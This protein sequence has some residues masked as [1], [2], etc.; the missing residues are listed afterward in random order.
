MKY[1]IEPSLAE[2]LAAILEDARSFGLEWATFRVQDDQI[3]PENWTMHHYEIAARENLLMAPNTEVIRINEFL[4]ELYRFI[5][6]TPEQMQQAV[7][8]YELKTQLADLGFSEP[9]VTDQLRGFIAGG[10]TG[11]P[12]I[13]ITKPAGDEE[14]HFKLGFIQGFSGMELTTIA[15]AL[16]IRAK[17][18][19]QHLQYFQPDVPSAMAIELLQL[20]R[21]QPQM[22]RDNLIPLNFTQTQEHIHLLKTQEKTMNTENLN[23]LQK[24]LL[25]LGFGEKLNGALE[26]NI[27]AARKEFTLATD[28]EY[29][30]QNV[31]YTL[32][33]KAGDNN[34]M[35]FFNKYDAALRDKEMQQTFYINKGSG[36]TAKEAYNLMEGRAVHKQLENLEGEKYHAWIVIDKEN[37]T[38][39]GNFKLRPFTEGWN[40]K[41]E[42]AIDKLD[43]VGINEEGAREKLMKSLEKGN[44]HQVTAMKDGK[45]VKLYLE[46]NPAEH[47]VNLTNWK[48]EAQQLEHYKR[49]ELKNEV[50][51]DQKQA[52][53]TEDAPAKKQRKGAKMK[54]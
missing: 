4:P 2:E 39:N 54:V 15:C 8:F 20:D 33:F 6:Q 28:Q 24:Q 27:K 11:L 32:H 40:Y 31:D 3:L 10:E 53:S 9:E 37:K 26:N 47:R 34:E 14:A 43:I 13:M 41:P 48:G 44:R 46:A 21:H 25:N 16:D 1:H 52:Q 17:T 36:I 49:P 45:E 18:G 22:V 51:K 7:N 5:D 50:K 35:Y 19:A 23:Y 30:K 42:R 29:N 38:E 12:E